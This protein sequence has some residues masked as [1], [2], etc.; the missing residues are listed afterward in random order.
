MSLRLHDTSE[1]YMLTLVSVLHGVIIPLDAKNIP[2]FE[3]LRIF[4][5]SGDFCEIEMSKARDAQA[6]RKSSEMF[7]RD[8]PRG[9][10]LPV[11]EQYADSHQLKPSKRR[12]HHDITYDKIFSMNR[13]SIFM[14]LID[15]VFGESGIFLVSVHKK[16]SIH[17]KD[18]IHK[19]M[20]NS[21]SRKSN[22]RKSN[23]RKSNS[24]KSN[25]RKSN[26]INSEKDFSWVFQQEFPV[27]N[28][29]NLDD[30][31]VFE[32]ILANNNA[33][34]SANESIVN[35]LRRLYEPLEP[36][37]T[38][39]ETILKYNT[40][41]EEKTHLLQQLDKH[42]KQE[43]SD[44]NLTIHGNIITSIKMS[45]L[46]KVL[47]QM[48]LKDEKWMT[49]EKNIKFNL[50]DYTC[51]DVLFTDIPSVPDTRTKRFG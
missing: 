10:A 50:L 46:F 34:A 25:S 22:S 32:N 6:L 13:P 44:W 2:L 40:D 18:S 17:K 14:S 49:N 30:L 26:S 33:S 45:F 24:R 15:K 51:S 16:V 42:F 11:L 20:M 43:I 47:Q 5:E 4:S 8:F 21:I 38:R 41:E 3:N 29:L 28:L 19:K 27:L 7:R 31:T 12:I 39:K 23:S 9:S 35:Q 1:S 36:Y 37:T 48:F